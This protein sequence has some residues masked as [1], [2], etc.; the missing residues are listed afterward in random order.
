MISTPLSSVTLL[1][2]WKVGNPLFC[3]AI[4]ART[5]TFPDPIPVVEFVA[6]LFPAAALVA[7]FSLTMIAEWAR[8][9]E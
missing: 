3:C 1:T 8:S 5:A 9:N 4:M 7:H 2:K 6:V